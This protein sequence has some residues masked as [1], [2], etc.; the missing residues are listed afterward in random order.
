MNLS[1]KP[2]VE[3][4]NGVMSLK[5][6]QRAVP[7]TQK[8]VEAEKKEIEDDSKWE[9][10]YSAEE[11]ER[12]GSSR[13]HQRCAFARSD[14]V[15]Y[16]LGVEVSETSL[17]SIFG[18]CI[19]TSINSSYNIAHEASYIPFM[20]P[21][22]DTEEAESP[23]ARRQI[24]GRR[25]FSGGQE[26]LQKNDMMGHQI[27]KQEPQ[28]GADSS[29]G[30]DDEDHAKGSTNL[31]YDERHSDNPP[32]ISNP[33]RPGPN[34]VVAKIAQ[35]SNFEGRQQE[36]SLPEASSKPPVFL[37]PQGVDV[38]GSQRP[39]AATNV[40]KGISRREMIGDLI[41]NARKAKAAGQSTPSAIQN[42]EG[43]DTTQDSQSNQ[44][45]SKR[46][47]TEEESVPRKKAR[48]PKAG[49]MS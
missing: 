12:M 41:S 36:P 1:N 21:E 20:F 3:L 5:F 13:Q 33:K 37:R 23:T 46:K 8:P 32:S 4:S 7:S 38:P 48:R 24:S 27:E 31:P 15:F 42:V 19:T 9:V 47:T 40:P 22:Q 44:I 18:G 29:P 16:L 28:D 10:V 26:I 45:P 49:A 30:P 34:I 43:S 35:V 17:M 11:L 39:P 6:M 14:R 25:I 2:P